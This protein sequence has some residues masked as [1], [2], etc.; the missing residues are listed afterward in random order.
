MCRFRTMATTPWHLYCWNKG[1]T[2]ERLEF[3]SQRFPLDGYRPRCSCC[4]LRNVI[5]CIN[6]LYGFSA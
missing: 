5:S 6:V 3:V 4:I 1:L 2:K